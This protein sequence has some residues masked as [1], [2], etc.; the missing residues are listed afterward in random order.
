VYHNQKSNKSTIPPKDILQN[1]PNFALEKMNFLDGDEVPAIS[2]EENNND[3]TDKK[4]DRKIETLTYYAILLV[5]AQMSCAATASCVHALPKE[6]PSI[7][8][9]LWRQTLTMFI[10]FP[11]SMAVIYR[12]RK[13]IDAGNNEREPL[14][15]R[16]VGDDPTEDIATS[17]AFTDRLPFIA[18]AVFGATLLNNTMVVALQYASSAAVMCLVNTTPMWLILYSVL[19]CNPPG[20]ITIAGASLSLIGAII[21]ASGGE[22]DGANDTSDTETLGAMIATMGGI[23]AAMYMTACSNLSPLGLH[24]IVLTLVINIGMMSASLFLCVAFLEEGVNMLS[25]NTMNGFWGFLNPHA[26]PPA[27]FDSVFPDCFGNFGIMISLSYFEPLIVSMVMLTEPLNAS[28]IAMA[29]VGEAPPSKRTILGVS[30]VL[31]GCAVVLWEASKDGKDAEKLEKMLEDQEQEYERGGGEDGYDHPLVMEPGKRASVARQRRM[32]QVIL[33]SPIGTV[34]PDVTRNAAWRKFNSGSRERATRR[35]TLPS[36]FFRDISN[37]VQGDESTSEFAEA[38]S[39]R[40]PLRFTLTSSIL[41]TLSNARNP[42]STTSSGNCSRPKGIRDSFA[43]FLES[44]GAVDKVD[45]ED[46]EDD[47]TPG[48]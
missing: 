15:N 37:A 21:C 31:L 12:K 25:T 10:F 29:V 20:K 22:G 4:A 41:Q 33:I 9:G 39:S 17:S 42:S 23:G 48:R 13:S 30:V 27:L 19:S 6:T 26:N 43:Q 38:S 8:R 5:A 47:S 45:E 35:Q 18:M 16:N 28:L 34:A 7:L 1:L 11:L 44:Y 2:F 46:A 24:P 3:V 40:N 14:V 36:N 32:S